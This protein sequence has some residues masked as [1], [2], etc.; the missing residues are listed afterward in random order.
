[1]LTSHSRAA[2]RSLLAVVLLGLCAA[3][4]SPG[5]F[6][7]RVTMIDFSD[8]QVA[9][10]TLASKTHMTEVMGVEP[11]EWFSTER[12]SVELKM[13]QDDEVRKLVREL[14]QLGFE[15]WAQ[16]GSG[17]TR[18][19]IGLSTVLEVEVDG[20]TQHLSAVRGGDAK[21]LA[22]VVKMKW[23]VIDKYNRAV[24][25]QTVSN[26]LGQSMFEDTLRKTQKKQ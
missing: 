13:E 8:A 12:E 24:S 5:P 22:A 2:L 7:G 20:Q 15:S 21:L 19:D 16:A 11:K 10:L 6:A 18:T 3:C 14:H 4:S 17:P 25:L 9:R 23:A 1:M 26:E